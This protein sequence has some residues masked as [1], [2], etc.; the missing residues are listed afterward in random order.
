MSLH[1]N[2]NRKKKRNSIAR[3]M[4]HNTKEGKKENLVQCTEQLMK[5]IGAFR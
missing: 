5:N 1:L 3:N 2:T 4:M